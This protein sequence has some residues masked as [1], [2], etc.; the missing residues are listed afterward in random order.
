[1]NFPRASGVLLHPTSLPSNYGIG[2]LGAN[3]YKFV[4][5]L[6]KAK[7]TYWQVLPLG[8]TGYGDSPYQ[9]FSTFAGNPLLIALDE[10]R[11]AGLLDDADLTG[12]EFAA[13]RVDFGA[14]I[15][16]KVERLARAAERFRAGGAPKWRGEYERFRATEAR[17]LDDY[18]LFRA[19]KDEQGGGAWTGWDAPLR[20][21]QADALPAAR[22]RLAARI[23][24]QHF[25]QFIFFRQWRALKA[26]ANAAGVQI[27]GDLPIYVALDSSDAW[28]HQQLFQFDA[29]G[30]PTAV[31]GV[32]PDYFSATGQLWGNPLYAWERHAASDYVWWTERLRAVFEMVDILRID[33]FRGFEAYWSVPAGDM[34]AERGTWQPGPGKAL[35][36]AARVALSERQVIAEDLGLITPGVDALRT[37]LGYPGMAVLQFAFGSGADNLYL[38]HN[39]ERH[40]VI[41][42][43]THDNDTTHGWYTAV[44]DAT[45]D[46]VRRYLATTGDDVAWDLLRAAW[47]A[48]PTTAVAPLQDVLALGNAAR[49][50]L[51]GRAGGNWTWRM[52]PDAL[53]DALAERLR[54]VTELYGRLGDGGTTRNG[55]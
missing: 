14:V 49:M 28:A 6:G 18:A 23:D 50:N 41:Y 16:W 47:A 19:I 2:D 55:V 48:V 25:M 40:Y 3:A 4:D 31:S 51:P 20:L 52:P 7:Q 17:W 10:L 30:R 22:E 12:G 53:T 54:A 29:E 8:P 34:T 35:F 9:A 32:P 26:A 5:F 36:D 33:H 46:H 21:R 11:E 15:P 1:M 42:T 45:R 39:L 27:I 13:G 37:A 38:P 24:A 43:G 44:G